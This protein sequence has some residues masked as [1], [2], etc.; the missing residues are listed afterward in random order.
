MNNVRA[1]GN[2]KGSMLKLAVRKLFPG[3]KVLITVPHYAYLRNRPYLLP[4]VWVHRMF[5]SIANRR[6]SKNMKNVV[7][8][9]FVDQ[10]TIKRREEVY[11][12]WGL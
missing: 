10:E 2:S 6:V 7:E 8:T 9:S 5:R 4:G 11:R 3:Y 1:E 12:E